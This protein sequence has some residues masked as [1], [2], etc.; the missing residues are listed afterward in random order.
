MFQKRELGKKWGRKSI[1]SCCDPQRN[2]VSPQTS[3]HMSGPVDLKNRY[4]QI[5]FLKLELLILFALDLP[6][7]TV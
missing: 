2:Y 7:E 5:D 3:C 6:Q 4:N 1:V